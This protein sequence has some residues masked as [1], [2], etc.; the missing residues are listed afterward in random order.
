MGTFKCHVCA[1]SLSKQAS[2]ALLEVINMRVRLPYVEQIDIGYKNYKMRL[3]IHMHDRDL[4][5]GSNPKKHAHIHPGRTQQHKSQPSP[6]QHPRTQNPPHVATHFSDSGTFDR[7][8]T[9]NL[10][11]A[12]CPARQAH[13]PTP[14]PHPPKSSYQAPSDTTVNKEDKGNSASLPKS[15]AKH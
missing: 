10:I 11:D 6:T 1:S 13:T 14:R 5:L 15:A 9:I 2:S 4:D 12:H 8:P 3:Y 7:R